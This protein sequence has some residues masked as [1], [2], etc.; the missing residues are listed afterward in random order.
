MRVSSARA[1]TGWVLGIP[2]DE[3]TLKA[4][5]HNS[6]SCGDCGLKRT[7]SPGIRCYITFYQIK[8]VLSV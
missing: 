7:V 6:A 5:V 4:N 2:T 8:S 1:V 3:K